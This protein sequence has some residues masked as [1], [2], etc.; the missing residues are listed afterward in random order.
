MIL[1]ES[2]TDKR[3]F[4]VTIIRFSFNFYFK[5]LVFKKEKKN[6][7]KIFILFK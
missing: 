5:S 4:I 7:D 6:I 1:R 3:L 2:T